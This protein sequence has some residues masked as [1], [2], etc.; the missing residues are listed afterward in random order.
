MRRTSPTLLLCFA[1]FLLAIPA[2]ADEVGSS[3]AAARGSG[4]ASHGDS[5]WTADSSAASQA[6]NGAVGH[7]SI[8]HLGS[9]CSRAA[10]IVGSGPTV[11]LVFAGFRASATHSSILSDPA[12][13]AMG[14]GVA[15]GSDGKLYISVIFCVPSSGSVTQPAPPTPP[16]APDPPPAPPP[17]P[18][19]ET[20]VAPV[21]PPAPTPVPQP[22]TAPKSIPGAPKA[23]PSARALSVDLERSTLMAVGLTVWAESV[24]AELD[25][26]LDRFDI[27][28][29]GFTIV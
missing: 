8:T 1:L 9:T 26:P 13:T 6:A 20:E 5:E 18:P 25:P 12:W 4:L 27:V 24:L 10:E 14:S 22:A 11:Q 17:E 7:A 16:P 23:T 19:V 28:S 15:K 3:V 2:A 21:K 29:G